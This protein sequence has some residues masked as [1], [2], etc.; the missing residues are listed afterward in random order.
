MTASD[1][2]YAYLGPE[3]TFTE[4]ALRS[5]P[6]AGGAVLV[7]EP[8][9]PAAIDAVRR[10]DADGA[11]VPLENSV[12][13]TVNSTLDELAGGEPLLITAEVLLPVTLTLLARPGTRRDDVKR[14]ITHP[15]AYAQCR[16]W[17]ARHLPGAE[18]STATSTAAAA[19]AVAEEGSTY[20]AAIAA[21]IA[22]E[23]YALVTLADG[24]GDRDGAVTRFVL[25][26]RPGPLPEP[27]GA[28]R[29]SVVAFIADDHP[30]A[31]L[32][33]LSEFAVRGVNLTR[34]ESRPTG[35]RLGRYCFSIDCEGHVADARVGEAIMGL[36]RICADV[37]FLGSFPR[38][39]GAAPR[40]RPGTRDVDFATAEGWL[41]R[42]RRGRV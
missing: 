13:G 39:D 24:I 28:D 6:E 7:P 2:R 32:E 4:A 26:R 20:D 16:G 8:T 42:I 30:G 41:A 1:A 12:E 15:H 5:V 25:L 18:V 23:R 33:I 34:I 21:P 3:G 9:V 35:E 27:T 36:R 14:V 17:L 31:L 10:G 22:A 38:A 11:M 19:F 37:R 40:I 29:T